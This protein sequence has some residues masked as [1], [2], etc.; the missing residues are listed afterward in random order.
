MSSAIFPVSI[1]RHQSLAWG[2]FS[3]YEFAAADTV[4]P[5]VMAE[6]AKAAC[7]LPLAFI[8]R[9]DGFMPVAVLGLTAEKNAFVGANGLWEGSYVPAQYRGYPFLIARSAEGEQLFCVDEQSGLVGAQL[10]QAFFD[11]DHNL[12]PELQRIFDFWARLEA[13]R[14][15]TL[16]LTAVLQQYELIE[17][18]EITVEN[19]EGGSYQLTGLYR[20]NETRLNE[21]SDELFAQVRAQGALPMIYCQLFSMQHLQSVAQKAA[22]RLSE[23]ESQVSLTDAKGELDL[24]FLNQDSTINFGGL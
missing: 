9:D 11:Q 13:D 10:D 22:Q 8:A 7:E 1:S 17:P 16:R 5:V 21:L 15:Q 19:E 4:C 6:M 3:S 20:T 2:N 14:I 24:E 12:S 23:G 18:W